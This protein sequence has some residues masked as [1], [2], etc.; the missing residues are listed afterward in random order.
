MVIENED[1]YKVVDYNRWCKTC[2]Y[3]KKKEEEVPCDECLETPLN[4]ETTQPVKWEKK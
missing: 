3:E 4:F 1:G 2:K